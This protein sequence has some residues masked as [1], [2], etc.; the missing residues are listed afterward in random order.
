MDLL[1]AEPL[2]AEVLQWLD[3]RHDV[4]HAPRIAEDARVLRDALAQARAAMLPHGVAV[5]GRLL[6]AAPRLRAIGRVVGGPEHIDLN[7]CARFGVE[8]VRFPDASAPAEAEFML[9]ALMALMRPSPRERERGA[10]GREIG[11]STIGLVGMGPTALRLMPLLRACGARVLAYEPALHAA[12]ARWARSGA[13]PTGLRELFERSDAVG[14][15]LPPHSRYLGLLGERVLPHARRG[16]V[17]VSVSPIELFDAAALARVL[18]AG[19]LGA[20]WIDGA[21]P[22]VQDEGRP[23]HGVHRLLLTPRV[24]PYTR[25]ARLRSAWSVARRLDTV[26]RR[27]PR[28]ARDPGAVA[29][30]ILRDRISPAAAA[31]PGASPASR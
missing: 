19:V 13:Q 2:E 24:A 1:I 25:E 29:P 26:L 7:A 8:V 3:T 17:L 12:D 14:V 5:D 21:D 6:A 31:A 27:A 10:A 16:Q 4:F 28:T 20:A 15:S 30:V 18:R 9:G 11:H 22:G 23:L